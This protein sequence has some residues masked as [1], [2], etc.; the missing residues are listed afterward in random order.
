MF[1]HRNANFDDKKYRYCL[2]YNS[3]PSE[4]CHDNAV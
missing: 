4:C 3:D 2:Y 1:D